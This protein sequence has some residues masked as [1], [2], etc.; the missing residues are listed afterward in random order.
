MANVGD[1]PVIKKKEIKKQ[2]SVVDKMSAELGQHCIKRML[3]E[4]M[5]LVE[6]FSTISM[7]SC[8]MIDA[9]ATEIGRNSRELLNGYIETVKRYKTNIERK[10]N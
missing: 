8:L 1:E 3:E 5:S 2:I 6:I 4:K 9:L 7:I 10:G